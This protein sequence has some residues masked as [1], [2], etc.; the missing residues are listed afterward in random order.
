MK[1]GVTLIAPIVN[2]AGFVVAAA[3]VNTSPAGTAAG[4]EG[5]NRCRAVAKKQAR[6]SRM[7]DFRNLRRE[8]RMQKT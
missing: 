7:A 4:L 6:S 2:C 8:R 1:L 3:P 5:P